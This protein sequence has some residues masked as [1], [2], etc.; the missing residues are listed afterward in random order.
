M[1]KN[2]LQQFINY[3]QEGV[4]IELYNEAGLQHEL[5]WYLRNKI[6]GKFT[7]KLE[8]PTN[9]VGISKKLVKKEMDIYLVEKTTNKKYCIELKTP[10]NLQIPKI[11]Y[12]AIADV[13]FLSQL[14]NGEGFDGGYL[15]FATHN[16]DFWKIKKEQLE[17]YKM[18][19][20]SVNIQTLTVEHIP[21]FIKK[22]YG[23]I[24]PF[25]FDKSYNA[26]WHDL[27]KHGDNHWRYFIIEV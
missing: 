1:I 8:Y 2:A 17:I 9:K 11:M 14:V 12:N 16:N 27:R 6:G 3:I 18:F 15:L 5:A 23:R 21:K 20:G 26:E 4:D 7:I 22:D 10:V 13:M 25:M 24:N 19:R